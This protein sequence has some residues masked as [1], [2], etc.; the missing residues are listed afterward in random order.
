MSQEEKDKRIARLRPHQYKPGESGHNRGQ[1]AGSFNL[2]R[3]LR[4]RLLDPQIRHKLVEM[5]I[6]RALAGE[7]KALQLITERTGGALMP[8]VLIAEMEKQT[9]AANARTVLFNDEE[10]AKRSMQPA[11]QAEDDDDN[12]D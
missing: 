9:A 8:N 1:T 3:A 7:T 10:E 12:A 4:D 2:D 11:S 6:E 5:L